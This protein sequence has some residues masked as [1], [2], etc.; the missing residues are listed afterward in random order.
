MENAP[1]I[2]EKMVVVYTFKGI[3]Y[4][5]LISFPGKT[6]ANRNLH[7]RFQI[8]NVQFWEMYTNN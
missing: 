6:V 5:L 2:F 7:E 3:C 8:N 4:F 1:T